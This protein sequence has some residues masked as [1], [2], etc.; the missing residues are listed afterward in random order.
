[1][2]G[3]MKERFV[4]PRP[5]CKQQLSLRQLR[6]SSLRLISGTRGPR[7]RTATVDSPKIN[8]CNVSTNQPYL[9]LANAQ[10][11]YSTSKLVSPAYFVILRS[12]HVPLRPS[13]TIGLGTGLFLGSRG[14]A[15]KAKAVAQVGMWWLGAKGDAPQS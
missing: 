2:S 13:L 12:H 14:A 4:F 3:T 15:L 7:S 9:I 11:L 6:V 5:N 8:S 1:M 10:I